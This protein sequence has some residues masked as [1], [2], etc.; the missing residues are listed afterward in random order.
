MTI[1]PYICLDNMNYVLMNEHI[2]IDFEL[3]LKHAKINGATGLDG[4]ANETFKKAGLDC[5]PNEITK[6]LDGLQNETFK[7]DFHLILLQ[8]YSTS[9]F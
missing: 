5:L 9:S 6:N 4:L 2:I 3:A 1:T 7:N 8:C